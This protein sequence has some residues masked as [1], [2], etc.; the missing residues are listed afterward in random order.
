ML[1]SGQRPPVWVGGRR[2]SRSCFLKSEGWLWRL[3]EKPWMCLRERSGSSSLTTGVQSDWRLSRTVASVLLRGLRGRRRVGGAEPRAA[4]VRVGGW[5][6]PGGMG[7][8]AA[9]LARCRRRRSR[10]AGGGAREVS[11]AEIEVC[12]RWWLSCAAGL[13]CR[14]TSWSMGLWGPPTPGRRRP[15]L[16]LDRSKFPAP[17]ANLG[18]RPEHG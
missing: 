16:V 2:R 1:L 12:R 17:S 14:R 5:R 13:T 10:Y 15:V 4:A 8:S 9:E 7:A 6:G 3:A 11:T 18:Q